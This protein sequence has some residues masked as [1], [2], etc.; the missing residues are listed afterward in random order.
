MT[1]GIARKKV[2]LKRNQK[3]KNKFDRANDY[4]DDKEEEEEEKKGEKWP[5]FVCDVDDPKN[6]GITVGE[7]QDH[8]NKRRLRRSGHYINFG[9]SLENGKY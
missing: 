8:F 3:N 9:S 6:Y 2:I 5:T 1:N 4:E 7:L